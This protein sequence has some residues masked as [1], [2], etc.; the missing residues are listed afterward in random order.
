LLLDTTPL[1]VSSDFRRLWGGL[2]L[3]HIGSQLTI[4]A[5]GLQVYRIT[6]S[7]F[8]VGLVG[9]F[10]LVPLL[11]MGLYGGALADTRDRR[12]VAM[13]ASFV[14]WCCTLA[15]VAQ[16]VAGA[17]NV[18]VLYVLVAIQS[19]AMAVNS[20]ARG[21]IIPRIMPA[22]LLPAA[23]ALTQ[24]T[25]TIALTAGPLLGGILVASFGFAATYTVDAFT[26][27][28]A[29][30]AL[31]RLPPIPPLTSEKTAAL[32]GWR[33][34][35][36]GFRF[37]ATAPNLRMTFLVDMAAM[38]FAF[39]R[40]LFPAIA[41][42]VIGGGD[43]TVGTLTAALAVGSAIA[44]LLSGP[45]SRS[46]RHGRIIGG[47]VAAWG[48]SIAVFGVVI[49]LAGSTSPPTIMW[50]TMATACL[51]LACA[52]AADAVSAV[53]RGTIL[54]VAAPDDMRGRLQGVFI[55]VVAGGPR[56]G[57]MVLGTG[58]TAL[59]EGWIAVIGG[60]AC[61]VAV[62][63]LMRLQPQFARYDARHPTP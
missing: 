42:L 54:Q 38:I 41:A 13:T 50:G 24:V 55:V 32:R 20:P 27:T 33:A 14:M 23:N 35:A 40:V 29:L 39:P 17:S 62:A 60:L 61:V 49:V 1:R 26:F 57:D 56:F 48:M 52:G 6:R 53:L 45:V 30:Y 12:R 51:A 37:L 22:E 9:L 10:A 5:I 21:A 8:N 15:L 59:T 47:A 31:W 36:D 28:A 46:R 3:A 44:T 58:A 25:H 18:I 19:G 11:V 63:A 7:T 16:A 2:A 34:V 4:L 43:T